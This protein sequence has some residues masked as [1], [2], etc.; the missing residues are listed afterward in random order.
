MRWLFCSLNVL[1]NGGTYEEPINFFGIIAAVAVII[2]S[3]T[4]CGDGS[5]PKG[6]TSLSEVIN[7]Y[8]RCPI[9]SMRYFSS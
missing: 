1:A 5:A 9:P 7:D 2:F 4:A 6:L 3:I 8:S